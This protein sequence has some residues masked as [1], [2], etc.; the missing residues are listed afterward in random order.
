MA[1]RSP[2][3]SPSRRA[4]H[5][6]TGGVVDVPGIDADER[7]AVID[8][9]ARRLGSQERR[10]DAVRRGGPVPVPSRV[11][12]HRAPGDVVRHQLGDAD[13]ARPRAGQPHDHPVEGG[14]PLER[15]PGE[16]DAAVESMK[17]AVEVGAGVATIEIRP[18]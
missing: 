17:R 4:V 15:Q 9:P 13:R 11:E 3:T 10:V 14:Q 8:Q 7:G 18:M 12:Q 2:G 6:V 1:S 5:P 16:V